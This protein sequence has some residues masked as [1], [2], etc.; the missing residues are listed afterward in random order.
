ME[1]EKSAAEGVSELLRALAGGVEA[2]EGQGKDSPPA[3]ARLSSALRPGK[4][5]RAVWRGAFPKG[6][7]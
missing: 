4:L 1:K 2:G 7:Q 5:F 3:P 6:V